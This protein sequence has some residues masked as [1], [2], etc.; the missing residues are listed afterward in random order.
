MLS[1]KFVFPRSKNFTSDVVVICESNLP[2]HLDQTTV[3]LLKKETKRV[4]KM[5]LKPSLSH[6]LSQSLSHIKK[7]IEGKKSCGLLE[8]GGHW[9]GVSV[10]GGEHSTRARGGSY[11]KQ[12]YD[13]Q[14]TGRHSMSAPVT[15]KKIKS[16]N[17]KLLLLWYIVHLVDGTHPTQRY[18]CLVPHIFEREKKRTNCCPQPTEGVF[19][20]F[21]SPKKGLRK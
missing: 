21:I 12:Q 6:L 2:T 4:Y 11:L 9:Q 20:H 15:R 18:Y 16:I 10:Q 5:N 7:C 17:Q 3:Y 1:Q 14:F 13:T 19:L 8:D